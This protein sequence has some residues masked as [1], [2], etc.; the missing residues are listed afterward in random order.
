VTA[1][2]RCDVEGCD[3]LVER[4]VLRCLSC[5]TTLG[6][7]HPDAVGRRGYPPPEAIA[8]CTTCHRLI[9]AKWSQCHRCYLATHTRPNEPPGE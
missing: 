3:T 5:A 9:D 8:E 2:V 6:Q 4:H 1:M 7:E